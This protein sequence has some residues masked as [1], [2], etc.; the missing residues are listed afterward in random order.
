[1]SCMSFYNL[2]K[3]THE[4]F[5]LNIILQFRE[6][7]FVDELKGDQAFFTYQFGSSLVPAGNYQRQFPGFWRAG[8]VA[9]TRYN[10]EL[11][12]CNTN[13]YSG[14]IVTGHFYYCRKRC[15]FWCSDMISPFFRSATT[16]RAFTGVAFNVNGHMPLNSSLISVGLR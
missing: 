7:L 3:K 9:D 16:S 11:L 1:M 5:F 14:F 6:I 8:G 10:Y 13:F 4:T 12:I 15:T 2:F